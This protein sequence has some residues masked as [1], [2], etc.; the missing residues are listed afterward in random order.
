MLE[1]AAVIGRDFFVGAVR[2]LVPEAARQRVPSDLMSLVRKELI[3]PERID[4]PG[5]DAFRFRHL[6][7]RDRRTTRSRRPDAPSCT[8]ASR[9]GSS[10]WQGTRQR[11]GGDRRLPPGAGPRVPDA[12]RP[13][14]E[15]SDADRPEGGGPTR[16]GWSAGDGPRRLLRRGEL[17]RAVAWRS[18]PPTDCRARGDPLPPRHRARGGRRHP[19]NVRGVRRGDSARDRLRRPVAGVA[20][21]YLPLR[22]ADERRSAQ[23]VHP[24]V[25]RGA[26]GRRSTSSMKLGDDGGLGDRV[27]EARIPR[28]HRRAAIDHAERRGAPSR[29][30]THVGAATTGSSPMPSGICSSSQMFRLRHAGGRTSDA[31]RAARGHRS[32]PLS[33]R[34]LPS[35]SAG[36]SRPCRLVRQGRRLT[37]SASRSRRRS[38][39]GSMVAVYEAF[40]G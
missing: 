36:R 21:S 23:H 35:L 8:S 1:A 11:A 12:A 6:L 28:V 15:R 38:G 16:D 27:G 40:L 24:G 13:S 30:S 32:D 4:V 5:E 10:G 39:H 31:G 26:R 29:R 9:T 3:H 25:P 18:S 20:R 14:D 37:G 33:W 34:R 19:G 22:G 2:E 7:I 17:L